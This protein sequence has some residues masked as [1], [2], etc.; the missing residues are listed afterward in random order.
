MRADDPATPPTDA[1]LDT[2]RARVL[3]D[4]ETP[5]RLP[6]TLAATG[7]AFVAA[8][9]HPAGA[10]RY[11]ASPIPHWSLNDQ[12]MV[13]SSVADGVALVSVSR[14]T[15]RLRQDDVD[16]A[17]RDFFSRLPAGTAIHEQRR[18]T[19]GGAVV[20]L[21]AALPAPVAAKA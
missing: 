19:L 1:E 17:R 9:G 12:V 21:S 6:A 10:W 15:G 3:A 2:A 13:V 7:D 4:P 20:Y 11:A 5:R 16:R 14:R 8:L 18:N